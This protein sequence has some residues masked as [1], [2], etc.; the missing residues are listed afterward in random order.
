MELIAAEPAVTVN[1]F[2]LMA[3]SC[4]P[5]ERLVI[6]RT[7]RAPVAAIGVTVMLTVACVRSVTL[8][9]LTVIP[10]P[11]SAVVLPLTKFENDDTTLTDAL[12]PCAAVPGVTISTIGVDCVIVNVDGSEATSPA[13]VRVTVFAS[14]V[15]LAAMVILAVALVALLMVRV[16]S[17]IPGPKVPIVVPCIQFVL[18]PVIPTSSEVLVGP[19][20]GV[21]CVIA[22]GPNVMQKAP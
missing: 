8:T 20:L 15:A 11:K 5:P 17:E 7:V 14:G 18:V 9:L 4:A 22:A 21:S 6:M 1:E 19:V 2:A 13:V 12:W 16:F 10:V 3:I